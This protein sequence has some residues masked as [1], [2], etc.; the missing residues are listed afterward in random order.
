MCL[1]QSPAMRS[2]A[3]MANR[4]GDVELRFA[5]VTAPVN[6]LA[7]LAWQQNS[8]EEIAT[9]WW[10]LAWRENSYNYLPRLTGKTVYYFGW[11]LHLVFSWATSEETQEDSL[12]IPCLSIM[13]RQ[14]EL[15]FIKAISTGCGRKTWRVS[16]WNNTT[17]VHFLSKSCYPWK[18]QYMPF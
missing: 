14:E 16:K 8:A 6:T 13:L 1:L 18:T 4:Q 7:W 3:G 11:I 17:M 12:E 2:N 10:K 5:H 9:V 15:A